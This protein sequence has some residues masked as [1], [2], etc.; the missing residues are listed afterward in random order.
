MKKPSRLPEPEA[1]TIYGDGKAKRPRIITG[2]FNNQGAMEV[3]SM[4]LD[5][6]GFFLL[7][8][9][10][11]FFI[12]IDRRRLPSGVIAP[13]RLPVARGR[14][15]PFFGPGFEGDSRSASIALTIRSFSA[16]RSDKIF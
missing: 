4:F 14:F 15:T 13:R 16:V 8:S 7:R 11:R 5:S 2:V 6:L 1:W 10:Q 9:A 12:A 3:K